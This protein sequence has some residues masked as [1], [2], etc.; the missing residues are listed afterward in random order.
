[1]LARYEQ[2]GLPVI[3]FCEREAIS[4]KSFH[5]WRLRL[6]GPAPQRAMAKAASATNAAAGFIDVRAA[7]RSFTH[8]VAP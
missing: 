1:M 7:R 4:S 2:S 3:A 6:N 5:R 8:R